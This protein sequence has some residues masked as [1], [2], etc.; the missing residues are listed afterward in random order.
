VNQDT[1]LFVLSSGNTAT[2]DQSGEW[3]VATLYQND[4]NIAEVD[5]SGLGTS[6]DPNIVTITQHWA[7]DTAYAA[8][9]GGEG[10]SITVDQY[11]GGQI[12]NVSPMFRR[13]ARSIPPP[14]CRLRD[15]EGT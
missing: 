14:S 8:Q 10:N 6:G 2:V 13:T 11:G 9:A 4:N 7:G 5:Q 15:P 3:N 12:A 1:D